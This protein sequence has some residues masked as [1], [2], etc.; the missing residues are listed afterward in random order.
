MI[1]LGI[2]GPAGAG[3]DT[4]ADYLVSNHDYHKMSF[5]GPLK[6]MLAA[7]GMPEP[8]DRALKEQTLPGFDFTWREAAQLLGT[9]WGRQLDPNIWVKVV[10]QAV[11][12]MRVR[13]V[14][15]DVRFEN[16]AAMIREM[17]GK[18]IHLTGRAVGLGAAA[19]HA[20]EIG[21]AQL[22]EDE[23]IHN[24]DTLGHL[25]GQVDRIL[26]GKQQ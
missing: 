26:K 22:H 19:G 14:L 1:L 23:W 20:S 16:E 10:R 9:E 3:K 25:Y 15:S 21:V 13:V 17:G 7:A 5:A 24:A 18:V 12:R 6:A 11:T 8:K 2:A 4:V